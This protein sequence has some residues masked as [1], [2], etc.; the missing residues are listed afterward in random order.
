MNNKFYFKAMSTL[1]NTEKWIVALVASH[2]VGVVV[3]QRPFF[4]VP[5]TFSQAAVG[6]G[7]FFA[8]SVVLDLEWP[9]QSQTK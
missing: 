7:V 4:Q 1:L 5:Q 6:F 3:F 9:N 2:A 8:V